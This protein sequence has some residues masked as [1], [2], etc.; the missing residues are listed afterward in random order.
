LIADGGLLLAFQGTNLVGI[1]N[2]Q[3]CIDGSIWLG[4]ART[5]PAWRR[6][7]VAVFLQR[8][9]IDS[10]RKQHVRKVR[11]WVLASNSPAL[12][13]TRKGGFKTVCEFVHVTRRVRKLKHHLQQPIHSIANIHVQSQLSSSKYL[14]ASN[15]YIGY[16]FY[17]IKPTWNVWNRITR[18]GELYGYGESLFVYSRNEKWSKRFYPALAAITGEPD[19]V[20]D[21]VRKISD[22]RKSVSVDSYLPNESRILRAWVDSGFKINDWG[23]RCVVFEKNIA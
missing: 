20:L 7:G 2:Y 19:E 8:A 21:M 22:V 9:V 23:Y 5:D 6:K 10:A 4:Q 11:M 13:A 15:G 3:K 12:A 16:S 18:N 1:T 17:I 14:R